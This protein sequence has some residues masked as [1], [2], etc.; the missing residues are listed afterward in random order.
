MIARRYIS[1]GRFFLDLFSSVPFEALFQIS[2]QFLG[3]LG[4][5]K[6][7]RITRITQVIRNMN[8]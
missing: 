3:L 7:F 6:L 1:G 8:V 4:M 2:N 5:L